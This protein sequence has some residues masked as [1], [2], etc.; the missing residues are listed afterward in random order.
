M[1]A[2]VI[3]LS[4]IFSEKHENDRAINMNKMKSKEKAQ[5]ARQ[6]FDV[7]EAPVFT[8]I[9]D[10]G[11][12]LNSDGKNSLLDLQPSQWMPP[13]QASQIG[14]KDLSNTSGQALYRKT[15]SEK[16]DCDDIFLGSQF[17]LVHNIGSSQVPM[18]TERQVWNVH[19]LEAA[20][21]RSNQGHSK[22]N[23]K[24]QPNKTRVYVAPRTGEQAEKRR[25]GLFLSNSNRNSFLKMGTGIPQP[26]DNRG[27]AHFGHSGGHSGRK[28]ISPLVAEVENDSQEDLFEDSMSNTARFD[29]QVTGNRGRKQLKQCL[30]PAGRTPRDQLYTPGLVAVPLDQYR[31]GIKLKPVTEI[32]ILYIVAT[33]NYRRI[34]NYAHFNIVQ[35]K[36]FD[37][38]MYTDK[39][40]VLCSPTGSGKTAVFEM[41]IVRLLIRSDTNFSR[42]FKIVYMAPIKA[43]CSEKFSDWKTKFEPYGLKIMELT[44]DTDTDEFYELQSV[45][46]ILTTPEKWDSMTR[47]WRDNKTVMNAICLFLIDEI[48]ILN[49]PTRGSVVEA[50][51]SRMKTIQAARHRS[52]GTSDLPALRFLA[53]S[54]TITNIEDLAEWLG[55]GK[56][57]AVHYKMDDSVRPV[58]LRK[59][60][61]GYHFAENKQSEFQFDISL[62]YKLAAVINTYS[63]SKP[64]LIFCATRKSSMQGAEILSKDVKSLYVRNSEHRLAL[65]NMSFHIKDSKL[66]D[67]VVKGIGYHHAGMDVQDRKLIEETFAKGELPVLVATSTLAMGVNLPA[68]LVIIKSTMYYNMGSHQEYPDTQ[69]LQMIGRAGRPQFDTSATA[70]IMTKN[71]TKMKYENLLNGTQLIESSLHKNLVEH[72]NAEIVLNTI[73]D[74]SVA[75]EWLKYTFLYIRVMKNPTYYGMPSGLTRQSIEKRLQDLCMKSLNQLNKLSLIQMNEENMDV[76]PT[77]SG[78]L[79]ARYCISYKT[80]ELFLAF[81]GDESLQDMLSIISKCQEFDDIKLRNNEKKTLNTLNKDKNRITIRYPMTGKIKT[82]DMKVNCLI[83]ATFGSL[84]IQDFALQQDTNRIFRAGIR[85]TRCLVE[86][87]SQK[88]QFKCLLSALLLCKSFKARLWEDSKYVS[89]QLDGIGPTLSTALVNAGLTTFEKL[90]E[91]DPREIELIVN[92]HP[93]FGNQVK[94]NIAK[95]PKY[96][97]VIEQVMRYSVN[98]ADIVITLQITNREALT[99]STGHTCTLLVGDADNK[100][101]FKQRIMDALLLKEIC[102][103]KKLEVKRADKGPDLSVHYISQDWVGLDVE[104]TYTPNYLGG[105]RMTSSNIGNQ[106]T[107]GEVNPGNMSLSNNQPCLH[108]CHNKQMCAHECCKNGVSS[109]RRNTANQATPKPA[110]T[111]QVASHLQELKNRAAT[112]PSTPSVNKRI[113]LEVFTRLFNHYFAGMEND[114][115]LPPVLSQTIVYI[116]AV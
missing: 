110:S 6:Y 68:H 77:E 73:T 36:V 64:V 23:I 113:R 100:V 28:I 34:F 76:R 20:S 69:V 55:H 24:K 38:V 63:D 79:M 52:K 97:L 13:T 107:K 99:N 37:D 50:V 53:I 80:A 10:F 67:L 58:R 115:H 31:M 61:L 49:D 94:D 91:K 101:I 74:I 59:V 71:S 43:L 81:K 26:S 92:R 39:C 8:D 17:P 60:V 41:A 25:N 103:T 51:A 57:P 82:T 108:T 29:T 104:C 12:L 22:S 21:Q 14:R 114:Q 35:S 111:K 89:K 42:N 9:P 54:A 5:S 98:T 48:H 40:L 109:K 116:C 3:D 33:E 16:G 11:T 2:G 65:Q 32:H 62:S 112:L 102:W 106:Q 1:M 18:S 30:T 85:V 47:K 83:Q 90:E 93:P 95:L 86:F 15:V 7:P 27:N 84:L 44:G 46:I 88:S 75:V 96:E 66:R 56:V 70:V 87:L 105:N 78:R 72:L 4:Q 19:C 45:N